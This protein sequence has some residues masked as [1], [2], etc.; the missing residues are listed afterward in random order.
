M[1]LLVRGPDDERFAWMEERNLER[2]YSFLR[3]CIEIGVKQGP[4]SF[5]KHLIMALNHIAVANVTPLGGCYR[6]H[7][8]KFVTGFAPHY[9][10]VPELVDHL[11][12]VVHGRWRPMNPTSLAAYALWR[13]TWIY[14]FREGNGRTASAAA[15]FLFHVRGGSLSGDMPLPERIRRSRDQCVRALRIADVGEAT[16]SGGFRSV[17]EYLVNLIR[18]PV[19]PPVAAPNEEGSVAALEKRNA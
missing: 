13:L 14:P 11:V 16:G 1:T 15:A 3:D 5:D 19:A 10:E 17:H 4:A 18:A 9:S 8:V 7:C 12:A 6:R 2:Q